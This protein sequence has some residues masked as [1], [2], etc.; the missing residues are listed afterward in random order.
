MK[1]IEL[2]TTLWSLNVHQ[3]GAPCGSFREPECNVPSSSRKTPSAV[4]MLCRVELAIKE[5]GKPRRRS[6]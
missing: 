3:R 2:K 1:T 4:W 5:I 6:T